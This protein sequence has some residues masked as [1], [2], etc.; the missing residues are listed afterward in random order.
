[1]N[2][3]PKITIVAAMANNRVIGRNNTMPWHLPEDLQHF[4]QTTLNNVI[5]LGRKTVDSMLLPL[6]DRKHIVITRQT[7]WQRQ[8]VLVAHSLQEAIALAGD[9][10]EVFVIG[11]GEIFLEAVKIADR[12]CLTMIDL[13]VEGDTY[14]PDCLVEDWVHEPAPQLVSKTGLRYRIANYYRSKQEG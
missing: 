7:D 3:K 12:L 8:G 5:I 14:F 13:D 11:G 2:H 1:M 4:K 9:V 6:P 10:P